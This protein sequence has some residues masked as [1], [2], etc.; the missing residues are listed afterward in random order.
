MT[1]YDIY[2]PSVKRQVYNISVCGYRKGWS[3][4]TIITRIYRE[5][6]LYDRDVSKTLVKEW[7]EKSVYHYISEGKGEIV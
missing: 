2:A 1:T 4:E 6:R 3:L 5:L 7:V